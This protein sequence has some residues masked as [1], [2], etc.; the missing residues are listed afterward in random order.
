MQPPGAGSG[1]PT[2]PGQRQFLARHLTTPGIGML[3]HSRSNPW[4]AAIHAGGTLARWRTR[5]LIR[6][7]TYQ[8]FHTLHGKLGLVGGLILL[9][10]FTTIVARGFF[11]T[12]PLTMAGLDGLLLAGHLW[13]AATLIVSARPK[14]TMLRRLILLSC[15]HRTNNTRRVSVCPFQRSW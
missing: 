1:L 7:L 6:M 15:N 11:E 12:L 10:M 3:K 4:Q 5:I 2:A 8:V 13:L 9:A 14:R